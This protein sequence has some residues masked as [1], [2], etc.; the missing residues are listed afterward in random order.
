MHIPTLHQL[1]RIIPFKE[2]IEKAEANIAEILAELGVS[3]APAAAPAPKRKKR[4]M[5]AAGKARI[6]AAQ[7]AR[8]AKVRAAKKP[9]GKKK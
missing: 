3:L 8:W 6:A 2:Q 9:V 5:S 1:K 7:K 4:K